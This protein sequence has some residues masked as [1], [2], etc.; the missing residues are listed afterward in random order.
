MI[1]SRYDA[2]I[3]AITLALLLLVSQQRQVA[4]DEIVELDYILDSRTS[5][6]RFQESLCRL[7]R[8]PTNPTYN[9]VVVIEGTAS[10]KGR[11]VFAR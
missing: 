10:S 3:M 8:Q 11:F 2:F 9:I 6:R 4:R 5:R 1:R 7:L